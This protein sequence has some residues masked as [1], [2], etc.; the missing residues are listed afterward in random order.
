MYVENKLHARGALEQFEKDIVVPH[1]FKMARKKAEQEGRHLTDKELKAIESENRGNMWK[2]FVASEH[3]FIKRVVTRCEIQD[4]DIVLFL[5]KLYS[6]L[7]HSIH[8]QITVDEVVTLSEKHLTK[9]QL[10]FLINICEEISL[11]VRIG[12]EINKEEGA[13]GK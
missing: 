8:G 4:I 11:P 6:T 3:K 10:C 7:S 12:N 1:N 5:Q 9:E 2:K 13:L